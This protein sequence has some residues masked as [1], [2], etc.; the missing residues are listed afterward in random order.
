[1]CSSDQRDLQQQQQQQLEHLEHLE[2]NVDERDGKS[3]ANIYS[4]DDEPET[5][6]RCDVVYAQIVATEQSAASGGDA[7]AAE[8][9]DDDD[10]AV[11]YTELQNNDMSDIYVNV[12]W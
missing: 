1:V 6:P 11:V 7:A 8:D 4:N 3:S 2:Q 9:N 5:E 10:D 12:P